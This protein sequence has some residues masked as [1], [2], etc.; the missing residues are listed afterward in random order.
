LGT[1][2]RCLF[3]T[4]FVLSL[5]HAL[6]QPVDQN[7][8][9]HPEDIFKLQ[10]ADDVEISPDERYIAYTKIGADVMTDRAVSTLR[11]LD[12]RTGHDEPIHAQE[13]STPRWAPD[14]KHIAYLANDS[15]GNSQIYT[16]SVQTHLSVP[17]SK[18]KEGAFE[19]SWSPNGRL[20]AFLMF[21]PQLGETVSSSMKKPLGAKWA[22]PLR[23]TTDVHY[24]ADGYQGRTRGH[25]H[26]FVMSAQ[27]GLTRQMTFGDR[28]DS[29][30]PSWTPDGLHLIFS[31]ILEPQSLRPNVEIFDVR[32]SDASV[33]QLTHR[34]GPDQQATVSPD[35]TLIAYSGF[36]EHGRDYEETKLYVMD[37]DGS[38]SRLVMADFD[39]D[40]FQ[41]AWANDG[42]AVIASYEDHGE[43]KIAR[44]SLEGGVDVL[45]SGIA[46]RFS[47]G[48]KD[49]FAFA[50][51]TPDRPAEVAIQQP[52]E[53]TRLLT[54]LNAKLLDG[55]D[56]GI[57]KQF[58]ASSSFDG[59]A[60]EAW[61]LLP[62][63]F[64][65]SK[66]Y[67]TILTIH[68]GPYGDFNPVWSTNFQLFAAAGYVVLFANERGSIGYGES[69]SRKIELDF[70]GHDY[71]DHMSIVDSAIAAG[72][73]DP[74]RLYVTGG[75]AG[76][77]MT[78]WI[79]GKTDRFKAAV[80]DKPVI[81]QASELLS[82]D[83]YGFTES[84]FG[85]LPWED[86]SV[87][88]K[89]SP[90]SLVGAVKTPTLIMVGDQ[91]HRTP[92]TESQQFYDALK[93]RGVT[94]EFVLVPGAGHDSFAARPS[95]LGE[96]VTVTLAWF[97]RF[98]P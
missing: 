49:S 10:H 11:L 43:T 85:K 91:D 75:S 27:S 59:Q 3:F 64:E 60:I 52:S 93:L 38:H 83:Q 36:D 87:F 39:R 25:T 50:V 9:L 29:G 54:H 26:L 24:Q 31:S 84:V 73:A 16:Y 80:I 37:R 81:N 76:G 23:I 45:A 69:F 53:R 70:P 8:L 55:K 79:I 77:E 48:V 94:A 46:G 20:L 68:G 98:Q 67:P 74:N 58:V 44:F 56:L 13:P 21:L 6:G 28:D 2:I 62:P 97:K 65:S 66:R 89:H 41:V 63:N 92:V 47:L 57:Q 7:K 1:I 95:Q 15:S 14:S 32:L 17:R 71:E 61:M 18:F 42:R 22:E 33:T 78:A 51:S 82:N 12:V 4:F 72:V 19:I 88:W 30:I 5:E 40:I 96:E 86:P 34:A 35:G 90:L